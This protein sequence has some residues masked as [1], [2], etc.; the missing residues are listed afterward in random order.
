[1]LTTRGSSWQR[2]WIVQEVLLARK[3]VLQCGIHK[4]TWHPDMTL[5]RLSSRNDDKPWIEETPAV[6]LLKLKSAGCTHGL[7]DLMALSYQS[8]STD[9]RDKAY[10]F[11]SIANDVPLD[12]IPVDYSVSIEKLRFQ[13]HRLYRFACEGKRVRIL[14]QNHTLEIGADPASGS[15]FSKW[16]EA[17]LSSKEETWN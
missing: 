10:A 16:L 11:L 14:G 12:A 3:L 5:T 2:V 4:M 13:V 8:K 15:E 6:R 7:I 17:Y 1:M 9:I